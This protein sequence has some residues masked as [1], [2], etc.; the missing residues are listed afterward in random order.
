MKKL[1]K[2]KKQ[3]TKINE[4]I[5]LISFERKNTSYRRSGGYFGTTPA[6]TSDAIIVRSYART[7][8]LNTYI[9]ISK[10]AENELLVNELRSVESL[11]DA[12][13]KR[14]R[15]LSEKKWLKS[16]IIDATNKVKEDIAS[17]R[18][19]TNYG[20]RFIEGNT[21]IYYA[22]PVYGH[23]DYNK[24]AAMPNTKQHRVVAAELNKLI[25]ANL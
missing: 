6:T 21:H 18:C 5:S 24:W 23:A 4:K 13:Y 8:Y 15:R 9:C 3:L 12:E 11:I 19:R 16:S 22:H 1:E 7:R 20:K 17:G 14:L 25:D 10:S 2:L